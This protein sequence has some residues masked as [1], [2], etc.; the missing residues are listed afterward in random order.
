MGGVVGGRYIKLLLEI[1]EERLKE[2]D[3][4]TIYWR[5]HR[6]NHE[7]SCK[8]HLKLAQFRDYI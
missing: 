1:I 4:I 8:P 7:P 3:S 2:I 6:L 5:D